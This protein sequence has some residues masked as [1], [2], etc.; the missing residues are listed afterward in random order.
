[1]PS[2]ESISIS[3]RPEAAAEGGAVSFLWQD[4]THTRRTDE[5]ASACEAETYLLNGRRDR[6]RAQRAPDAVR[7]GAI[8]RIQRLVARVQKIAK[9]AHSRGARLLLP[10]LLL[11]WSGAG[12]GWL[13][14][15]LTA[16][17]ERPQHAARC[18]EG[19][20]CASYRKGREGRDK[21]GGGTRSSSHNTRGL[22]SYVFVYEEQ[23][24]FRHYH[25]LLR[26]PHLHAHAPTIEMTE[27]Q[28]RSTG[29]NT[30]L[31]KEPRGKH[32]LQ[33][34]AK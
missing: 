9:E 29:R 19:H 4:N 22:A 10:P 1:M 28:R 20:K 33:N 13:R 7:S 30:S 15:H 12:G 23:K 32:A 17:N 21:D 3:M 24:A 5:C 34:E 8:G 16:R 27:T 18:R 31:T 26:R 11:L 2:G 25:Q 14:E 6:G